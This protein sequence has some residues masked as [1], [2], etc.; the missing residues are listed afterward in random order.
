MFYTSKVKSIKGYIYERTTALAGSSL[1]YEILQLIDVIPINQN[2]DFGKNEK[3]RKK[4]ENRE[5]ERK[6]E[7]EFLDISFNDFL[8]S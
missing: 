6:K 5:K 2:W 8:Q 4:G 3:R 7:T 1:C